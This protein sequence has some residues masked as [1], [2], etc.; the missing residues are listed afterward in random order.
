M[1]ILDR[2]R[3]PRYASA[4]DPFGPLCDHAADEIQTL[5]ATVARLTAER[6]AVIEAA[7]WDALLGEREWLWSVGFRRGSCA[8]HAS[9]VA[10]VRRAAGLEPEKEAPRG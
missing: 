9:A 5:R 2:L 1:D 6:D 3:S 4:S 8:D 7:I 10:A